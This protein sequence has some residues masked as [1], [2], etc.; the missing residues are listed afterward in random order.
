MTEIRP[1]KD[2]DLGDG[3]FLV[4]KFVTDFSEL[5]FRLS[6]FITVLFRMG[7]RHDWV[8]TLIH[9]IDVSRKCE[10]VKAFCTNMDSFRDIRK[11]AEKIEKISG[12]RNIVAHGRLARN[13]KGQ[14]YLRLQGAGRFLKPSS[15]SGIFVVNDILDQLENIEFCIEQLEKHTREL[16][17]MFESM[18]D[19]GE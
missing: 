17:V 9:T 1:L 7:E 14:L 11:T 12:V 2:I 3:Y 19:R 13:D 5:D 6:T 16:Q 4:G 8:D 18:Q 10:I 15:K